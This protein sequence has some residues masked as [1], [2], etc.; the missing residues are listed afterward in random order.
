MFFILGICIAIF[1]VLLLLFKK[2]KSR[3][4]KVLTIWLLLM[5][6]HQAIFYHLI[7]GQT[8]AYPHL[9]GISLPIPVLHG[10]LL[11][12]YVSEATGKR[13]NSL[14]YKL[15]HLTPPLLLGILAI[16]FFILS[17]PEKIYVFKNEGEGFEW[18]LLIHQTVITVCGIGYCIWSLILIR[19]HQKSIQ[20][21]FSNTDRKELQWLRYLTYGLICIWVLTIFFDETVTFTSIVVFVLFIGI[22]GINQMNVFRTDLP[23][24]HNEGNEQSNTKNIAYSSAD[25]KK[26]YAKSG[27][28]DE[29]AQNIY[30]RLIQVMKQKAIYKNENLSLN[31]LAKQL[32]V[33]PNHLSQVINEKEKKNFYNYINTLRIK[34]FIKLASMPE[35]Q[36]FTKSSLAFDCGFNSKSTFNKH[37]KAYTSKTPTEYFK[38][39]NVS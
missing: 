3:A 21:K 26:R 24:H 32:E 14:P 9:L 6:V 38:S 4:D 16:P 13:N 11:Y 22:F 29:M 36:K 18:Y 2:N 39:I 35:N 5:A 30:Q 1:L 12:F 27:L 10:T 33:H 34:E 19:N 23:L 28:S 15:L 7:S 8:F 17:G 25:I 31:E 37:F 20:Q